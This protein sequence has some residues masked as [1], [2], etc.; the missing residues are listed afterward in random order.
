[1]LPF[2]LV[3]VLAQ[4]SAEVADAGAEP[5]LPTVSDPV[6]DAGVDAGVEAEPDR[7]RLTVVTGTRTER[8]AADAV[9]ATEV[10]TRAQIEQ[11]GVRDLPQLLQQHPGVEM[12]YTN[13]GTGIR[14]QGLDPEYVLVL[15]DGQR[16]SGRSGS[17]V[18]I[19]RF[20]LREIE[21]VEIVKG[22]GAALYGADAMGGVINL[23]T[24][25]P[26]KL[27][28]GAVRGMF[29][30]LLEG[31]VRGH[32]GSKLGP[33]ELRAGAGYRTRNA[34]DW[35]PKDPETSGPAIRRIDGDLE[36]AWVPDETARVWA[37]TAYVFTDNTGVDINDSNA[38]FDRYQRTEQFDVWVGGRKA[39]AQGTSATVRGHFGLFRDQFMVD[40]R[41][42]RALDDYSANLTRLWE[43]YGQVDHK[44]GRHTLS[45]GVEGF[46][47][48][49]SS[50]RINPSNVQRGR[51]G[52]FLQDEYVLEGKAR[53][54]ISP[55]FRADVDTQFGWAPSPRLAVKID[56]TPALTFRASWGLG[57][58]PPSFSEL[59]LRFANQ[60]IGYIVAGNPNLKA[61]YSG[62][63]NVSVDYRP[64]IEGWVLSLS[65][66]HTSLTNL[67]NITAN[68][69]PNPDDP[70]TF[71][72]ENVTN[73]Y[74]QGLE[75]SIR[76][77][78][79]R[80][81]YLDLAYMGIDARDLTRNRPLEGRSPHRVNATLSVKYRPVGLELVVRGT[82][83]AERPYYSG[84]GLGFANVLAPGEDR[85][86]IAPS[87]FDLE[88]QLTYVFRE[89]LRVFVNGYNLLNAGDQ[90][91]NPRPPRGVIGGIQVEL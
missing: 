61:E 25:R 84:S 16:I 88:A 72:Y 80:G 14:L 45:G 83:H 47:E 69:V 7:A 70:V 6:V 10:I 71:S 38:V 41:G 56:P 22:P 64:P 29:G 46:S 82:W 20:S 15:V 12:V 31:D 21:R 26:K 33:F 59:Y 81:A 75:A 13:R 53:V 86:I 1:M 30:S 79:S 62:S 39:F 52:V 49:L 89:W 9:V 44:L 19:S 60:G 87:Y 74:T 50:S 28:E 55:G 68:G 78:L 42:S 24:R 4:A 36:V 32:L 85:T 8:R 37:R 73:A 3:L 57:F 11:L 90:D 48:L 18:D 27:I 34:F 91:F 35:I 40:Q 43:G 63:A 65:G 76:A 2:V 66:W 23:I 67:I 77:R 58:R 54:A 5:Q 17:I 51:V